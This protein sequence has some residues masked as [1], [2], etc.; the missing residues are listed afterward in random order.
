MVAAQRHAHDASWLTATGLQSRTNVDY[1]F[2]LRQLL[3]TC[4]L[5][6][7]PHVPPIFSQWL[8]QQECKTVIFKRTKG[9]EKNAFFTKRGKEVRKDTA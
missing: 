2:F 1:G 3:Q 5:H 6:H 9:E 8:Q 7:R 4:L